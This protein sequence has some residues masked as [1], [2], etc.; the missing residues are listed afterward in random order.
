MFDGMLGK[1]TGS[2]YMIELKEDGK[3][4]HIPKIHKPTLKI[5]IDRLIRIGVLK[6]INNSQWAAPTF[7]IPKKNGSVRLISDFRKLNI[8]I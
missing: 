1:Y 7:I 8:I 6:N 3:T 4:L 2:D 5:E